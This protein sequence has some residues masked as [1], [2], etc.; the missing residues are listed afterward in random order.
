METLRPRLRLGIM[1]DYGHGVEL[2]IQ[3]RPSSGI[4]WPQSKVYPWF[5]MIWGWK[6]FQGIGT[7][8]DY[9]EATKWWELSSNAGLADSQF[10]LGAW[11]ITVGL[12]H[13]QNFAKARMS[14]SKRPQT[15]VTAMHNTA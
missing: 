3:K 9:A 4:S 6:Y 15:R 1:Y 8:Q 12:G 2:L 7:K 11:C 10:N 13:D 5:N 14:Y